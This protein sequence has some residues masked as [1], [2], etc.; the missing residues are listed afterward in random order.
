VTYVVDQNQ[1]SPLKLTNPIDISLN[2]LIHGAY[3]LSCSEC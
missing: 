1:V 2:G 3:C